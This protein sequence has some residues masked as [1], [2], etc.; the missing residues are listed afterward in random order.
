MAIKARFW[1][2][3]FNEK[4]VSGGG[5]VAQVVLSAVTRKTDDNVDWAAYTPAGR[6]E[7][8]VFERGSGGRVLPAYDE[9]RQLLG[10]DVIMTLEP[11]PKRD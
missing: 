2:T 10:T 4:V 1:V 6:L 3:E 9:F 8:Q 5:R 7:L 11:A